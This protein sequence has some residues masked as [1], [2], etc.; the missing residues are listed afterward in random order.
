MKTSGKSKLRLVLAAGFIL[1]FSPCLRA[2]D[3][4]PAELENAPLEVQAAY[5]DKVAR[6]SEAQKLEVGRQR[7]AQKMAFKQALADNIQAEAA[8]RLAAYQQ[9]VRAQEEMAAPSQNGSHSGI[10]AVTALV[11][12]IAVWARHRYRT[13]ELDRA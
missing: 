6:E 10:F 7:Y 12:V 2:I 13:A 8:T 4:L 11:I 3:P 5:R 1:A 9:Q